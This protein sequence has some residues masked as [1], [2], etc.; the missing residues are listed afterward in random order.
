[1]GITIVDSSN[2][3]DAELPDAEARPASVDL[4]RILAALRRQRWVFALWVALMGLLGIAYLATTPRGYEAYAT[5][6][7]T[8]QATSDIEDVSAVGGPD[9]VEDITIENALQVL[10]SQR[11]AL[12]VAEDLTLWEDPRFLSEEP[13]GL[14]ILV[15]GLRGYVRQA[16]SALRGPE[17]D[18][19]GAGAPDPEAEATAVREA[20]AQALQSRMQIF[21]V[22]RSSAISLSFDAQSPELAADVVNSFVEAYSADLVEANQ[23]VNEQAAGWLSQR[24]AQLGAEAQE[25]AIAVERF[26][27]ENGLIES[28]EGLVTTDS[29]RQ[30]NQEYSTALAEEAQARAIVE[31]YDTLLALGPEGLQ[32]A[33]ARV[34]LPAD[35]QRISELQANYGSLV[36][37]RD[38]VVESFGADHPEAVRLN[39]EVADLA[40]Q[41]GDEIAQAAA[42]AR[43][44]LDVAQGRVAALSQTLGGAVETSANAG[45]ALVELRALEQRAET[46]SNL[47]ETLLVQA[48]RANQQRTLPVSNLQVLSYASVPLGP[49]SPSTVRTLGLAV[50]LGLMAATVQSAFREWRD[51]YLRTGNDVTERLGQR[52]LGYLPFI[53][54]LPQTPVPDPA[55]R[56]AMARR[57]GSGPGTPDMPA[58]PPDAVRI[59]LPVLRN[60]RSYFAETLRNVRLASELS[61]P[62]DGVAGAAGQG[63]RIIGVTSLRA[64]E[65]KSTVSASLAAI[66]ASGGQRTLLVDADPRKADLSL[67]L[68]LGGRRGLASVTLTDAP[69]ESAMTR[70]E[71]TGVNV[72]G[73]E[74]RHLGPISYDLLSS[75]KM[76]RFLADARRSFHYV[77]LDLAPIGPIVDGRLLLSAVDQI[78]LVAEWGKTPRSLVSYTLAHEPHLRSRLLGVVLNRVNLRKL[79][80]WYPSP[81]LQD[82][83]DVD[84][85]RERGR[86]D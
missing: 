48:E 55:D 25:A 51:R 41:L 36:A 72:I 74:G 82:S 7:L 62:G 43:G 12:R 9:A 53:P 35:N 32:G 80:R 46:V 11:L 39:R 50:V 40:D 3:L 31:S 47:Y 5:V 24:V 69:M 61:W 10:R 64:G 78:V 6:L 18:R 65:G 21:R 68:G 76:G 38:D 70:I 8:G 1:M 85:G 27:T 49:S 16:L 22:G 2:R 20:A 14:A 86:A 33:N 67:R 57:R 52:F 63:G 13:S 66:L 54:G 17:P 34:L 73:C 81:D 37:R 83:Y 28:T 30:L 23:D 56:P 59:D 58:K 84:Y 77:V 60:P 26:R 4:G 15:G 29:V 42:A 75:P 71:G 79:A 19:A 45:E 44:N